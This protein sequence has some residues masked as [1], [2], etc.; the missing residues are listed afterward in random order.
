MA[1]ADILF[2]TSNRLYGL[3]LEPQH[4][5]GTPVRSLLT[6]WRNSLPTHD[7]L[8]AFLHEH[9]D[10][11]YIWIQSIDYTATTR[12]RM[13]P[14]R[15]FF[16]VAR[17]ERRVGV[18]LGMLCMLQ[19]DTVVPGGTATATGQFYL[20]PD[21]S[22]LYS[23]A[24]TTA[25]AASSATV[26]TFWRSETNEPLAGC[27][28]TTLQRIVHKLQS[29]YQIEVQCGFE[30]EVVF[31]KPTTTDAQTGKPTA[32]QPATTNH[33][34]SQMTS[35]TRRL[36]PL[37]EEIA[38]TLDG[39]GIALQQF[40]AES[41]PGQFE[42]V[43]PPSNPLAAVDSLLVART[44][45]TTVAD[46][47]GLRATL[48]PR[49]F[50]AYGGTSTH[51]HLSINPATQ[52]QQDAFLAGILA[53][54]P[55]ILAFTLPQDISYERLQ[56]GIWAGSEWIAWGFQ[57]REAP[58][59]KIEDRHWEF[60]SVDGLANPYLAVAALLA[61]GYI[62]INRNMELRMK[63]CNGK[64]SFLLFQFYSQLEVE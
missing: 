16:R 24:A 9:P 40:H 18:T 28:R 5:P 45:I 6:K 33:S 37:L 62:G 17:Q 48:H 35:D 63:D 29:Q 25:Q 61:G 64:F 11:K 42:F 7:K 14:I 44:A 10:I 27:P 23:N 51:A 54:Y 46:R 47:H 59:R 30:I 55:S 21:L 1:A 22:S 12:V 36:V 15:E 39:M 41:A 52:H 32:Y 19:D 26:M 34:W 2:H 4:T 56:P 60:K 50:Q 13:F 58:V 3:K 20:E 49:P 43:L 57:N 53:H 31:L 38:Q 8:D